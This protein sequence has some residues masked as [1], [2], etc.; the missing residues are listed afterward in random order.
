MYFMVHAILFPFIWLPTVAAITWRGGA[1]ERIAALTVSLGLFAAVVGWRLS[2]FPH[3]YQTSQSR[4]FDPCVE[5]RRHAPPET[6]SIVAL[7]VA[8][9]G[10]MP[11]LPR[12]KQ[13]SSAPQDGALQVYSGAQVA[14]LVIVL[15]AFMLSE[16]RACRA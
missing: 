11:I 2:L 3:L 14:W 10:F 9:L 12:L 8:L 4:A 7:L 1:E 16:H 6:L 13:F 15:G 5:P